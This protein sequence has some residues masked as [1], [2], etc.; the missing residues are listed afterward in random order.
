MAPLSSSTIQWYH[1]VNDWHFLHFSQF[2]VSWT[3]NDLSQFIE[4]IRTKNTNKSELEV[5]YVSFA[6]GYLKLT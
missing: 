2:A 6:T 4:I 1:S 3:K 5:Y